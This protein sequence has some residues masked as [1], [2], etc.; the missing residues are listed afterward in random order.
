MHRLTSELDKRCNLRTKTSQCYWLL[1]QRLTEDL[2][3]DS[4]EI[5]DLQVQTL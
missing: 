3:H 1:I 2:Q 5:V 4:Y